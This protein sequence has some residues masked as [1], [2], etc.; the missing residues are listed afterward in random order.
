VKK[1]LLLSAGLLALAACI[2]QGPE[3]EQTTPLS[4]HEMRERLIEQNRAVLEAFM[5]SSGLAFVPTGTGMHVWTQTAPGSPVIDT[6]QRV[7]LRVHVHSL[8][9][10]VFAESLRQEVAVL[11]DNDAIWGLQEALIRAH[12]G[13]S[14]ICIVPAH[15][16]HGLAGDLAD[17]PPLT[18]LVYYLRI[19]Q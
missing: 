4:A 12:V 14:L 3:P 19:L 17:I 1:V 5:D 2:R 8:H 9:G 7:Q 18:P 15:L 10:E 13:D 16:A 6:A 11:R